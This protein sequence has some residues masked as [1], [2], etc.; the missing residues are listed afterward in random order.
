FFRPICPK[1]TRASCSPI[2][3]IARVNRIG[4]SRP[5]HL[6]V[7]GLPMLIWPASPASAESAFRIPH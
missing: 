3:R 6:Y 1:F 7:P 5:S 4:F 2:L